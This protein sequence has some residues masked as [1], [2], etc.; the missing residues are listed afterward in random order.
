MA[1]R[2]L[3]IYFSFI[4][5]LDAIVEGRVDYFFDVDALTII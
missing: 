3:A 5:Q 2:I 1:F 4:A